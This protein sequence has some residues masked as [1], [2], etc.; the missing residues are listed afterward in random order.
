[1]LRAVEGHIDAHRSIAQ[2]VF[3][4]E[5]FLSAPLNP[6]ATQLTIALRHLFGLRCGDRRMVLCLSSRKERSRGAENHPRIFGIPLSASTP[7]SCS[8]ARDQTREPSR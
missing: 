5:R 8:S 2:L 4:L 7:P 1:M 3:D 6:R